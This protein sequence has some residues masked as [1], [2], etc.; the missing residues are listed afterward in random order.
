M[1]GNRA[2]APNFAIQLRHFHRRICCSASC[3]AVYDAGNL[4]LVRSLAIRSPAARANPP[5]RLNEGTDGSLNST[6]HSAGPSERRC[7][8]L[9]LRHRARSAFF[10][11]QVTV[12][13]LPQAAFPTIFRPGDIG[14]A[15]HQ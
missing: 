1:L 3:D 11:L 2:Q 6:I 15:A 12:S 13:P 8:P 10:K 5:S 9:S 4:F 7:S 14:A